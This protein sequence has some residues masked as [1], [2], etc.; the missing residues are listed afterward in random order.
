MVA[1]PA[2]MAFT[3]RKPNF[4]ELGLAVLW[5]Y[6]ALGGFRY[7]ALWVVI[8]IP[9]LARSSV[10]IEWLNDFAKRIGINADPESLFHTPKERAGWLFSVLIALVCLGGAKAMEGTSVRL[11]N[12]NTPTESLDL[13]LDLT[14][15]WQEK[16][17]RRP[18]LFHN[19]GWGGYITWHGWPRLLNSM[20]D[21]NEVQGQPRVEEHMNLMAALG[22]WRERIRD[23]DFVCISP[24]TA[25]AEQLAEDKEHWIERHRAKEAVIFERIE[26]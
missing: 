8:T 5:F 9:L 15:E 3:S 17:D 7:V 19:Y 16:H 11:T 22:S 24:D 26:R 4:V 13:L 23:F 10:A 6:L 12:K 1:F 2:L 14:K 18:I 25:L 21:R 20:D